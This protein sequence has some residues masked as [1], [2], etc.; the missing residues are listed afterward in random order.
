LSKAGLGEIDGIV[1]RLGT[2]PESLL[3]ASDD[4]RTLLT[5]VAR[6]EGIAIGP[7]SVE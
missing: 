4:A 3:R 5:T 6:A 7:T 1:A 2:E